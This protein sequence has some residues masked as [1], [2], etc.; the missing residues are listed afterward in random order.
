[1]PFMLTHDG[2][3]VSERADQLGLLPAGAAP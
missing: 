3:T 1:L 2:R